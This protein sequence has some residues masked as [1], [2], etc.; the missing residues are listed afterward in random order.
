MTL[1]NFSDSV[2][3]LTWID[4]LVIFAAVIVLAWLSRRLP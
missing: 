4:M 2:F 1:A 3:T